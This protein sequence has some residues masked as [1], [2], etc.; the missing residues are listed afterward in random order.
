MRV[1]EMSLIDF[2]Y[3]IF[4]T[5]IFSS[6]L[7]ELRLKLIKATVLKFYIFYS[8]SSAEFTNIFIPFNTL[9]G[10]VYKFLHP[11][12]II[13]YSSFTRFLLQDKQLKPS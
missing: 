5:L 3:L 1:Q 8:Y 11:T 10:D 7:L 13:D 2:V 4:G 6:G 12:A 9:L